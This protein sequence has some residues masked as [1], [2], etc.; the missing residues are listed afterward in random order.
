MAHYH[1]S[2]QQGLQLAKENLGTYLCVRKTDCEVLLIYMDSC[3]N[4]ERPILDREER[5]ALCTEHSPA[6]T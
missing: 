4:Q 2:T 3:T 6:D 5:M 1:R